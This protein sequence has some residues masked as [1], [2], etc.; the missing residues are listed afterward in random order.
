M[1]TGFF[2]IGLSGLAVAQLN[3]LATEHNIVNANTDGYTRQRVVQASNVGV[4]AG[5]GA[6]G[7]GVTPLT[8]ERLYDE[9]MVSQLNSSQ[10][11]ASSFKAYYAQISQ[12]DAMLADASAG[13]SPALQSFFA[14]VQEV[15]ANPSSLPARQLMISSAETMVSRFQTMNA[16]LDE[17][18]SQ[19]NGR[20]ENAVVEINAFASRV[21]DLNYA[22]RTA[23]SAY[24]QPA[25]DLRDQ[26][27]Q[28]V[29]EINKRIKLTTTSNDD[30]SVNLFMGSGQQLVV[31]TSAV[32]LTALE[33]NAD[34]SK[35]VIGIKVSGGSQ[36]LPD[37]LI[38][39][40]ELGGLIN[41]R[42]QSLEPAANEIGRVAASL[43]LTFN[44]QHE[45]GQ[46]LVGDISG[47]NDF[48]GDFFK[49]P[50]PKV[51]ANS[52][53][54]SALALANMTVK[55][56]PPD[57]PKSPDYSGN[58][59]TQ[60]KNS[61]YQVDF[62]SSGTPTI[63]RLSD[64]KVVTPVGTDILDSGGS[65]IGKN[66]K[67]DGISLDLKTTAGAV[68]EK[69]MIKP[70]SELAKDITVN[71]AIAADPRLIAA[72]APVVVK[73]TLGNTGAMTISQGLVG[74]DYKVTPP[75]TFLA[76][77][78]VLKAEAGATATA[79][80]LTGGTSSLW[81]TTSWTATYA[82]NPTTKSSGVGGSIPTLNASS[83][84]LVGI[85][86]S[87]V[88]FSVTGQPKVDDSFTIKR[89]VGGVQDGRN[90]ALFAKLQTQNTT[91]GGVATFQSTYS[92]L[93]ADNGVRTREA[94]IQ[95]EARTAILDQ[96]QAGRDSLSA[97]NM[98]EEAANMLKYQQAYQASSKILAI[99]SK[100]FDSILEIG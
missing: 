68:G 39:G 59:S 5:T 48:K 35:V 20:I 96:A 16:R 57:A 73:P 50:D 89:N 90:A 3:L 29:F 67:F 14:G 31:G 82:G 62:L 81:S 25:N 33:S 24:S 79:I 71:A 19:V 47:A 99:G 27:D 26:R 49:I 66:Y 28:L 93:V 94:K 10:T 30:G 76:S 75:A 23:E 91:D 61:S 37:S 6:V 56:A 41:F 55:F 78:I 46:N 83:A 88:S 64:N 17:I 87:G 60:L 22:I 12:I 15:S 58:F 13:I 97:V 100:L 40:G 86:F 18:S 2:S 98:D 63:T 69:Y 32:E 74:S 34:P 43:A 8:T 51:I 36:E 65:V 54:P 70:V 72:G 4:M 52:E 11:Q 53:N 9:F 21:A 44:A 84:A 92:R 45:L 38:V 80:N 1:S 42:N 77:D 95:L 7:Q 85:T